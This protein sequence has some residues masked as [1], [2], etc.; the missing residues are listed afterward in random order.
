MQPAPVVAGMQW[1]SMRVTERKAAAVGPKA[2]CSAAFGTY[3]VG[4][5]RER[6]RAEGIDHFD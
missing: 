4:R 5:G 2:A 1:H 6:Q 3:R